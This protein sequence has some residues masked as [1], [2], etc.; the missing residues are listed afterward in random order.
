[1]P[2]LQFE[3]WMFEAILRN[4][5]VTAI[6]RDVTHYFFVCEDELIGP[7]GEKTTIRS[8]GHHDDVQER[9]ELLS[10]SYDLK[11]RRLYRIGLLGGVGP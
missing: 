10:S 3:W 5:T 7:C 11:T 6:Q 4:T 2:K 9:R 8:S 1:M